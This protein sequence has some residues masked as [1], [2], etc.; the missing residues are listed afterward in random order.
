MIKGQSIRCQVIHLLTEK[1]FSLLQCLVNNSLAGRLTNID[2]INKLL[3]LQ[4]KSVEVQKKHRSDALISLSQ[5]LGGWLATRESII[6]KERS[7]VDRRSYEYFIQPKF[8][9]AIGN[10]LNHPRD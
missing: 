1:E 7:A 2:D 4:S 9:E 8:L 5:K 3:G 6:E 10:G